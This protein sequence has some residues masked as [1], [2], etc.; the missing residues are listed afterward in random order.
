MLP[1]RLR[2]QVPLP[3]LESRVSFI[4]LKSTIIHHARRAD[5][6]LA[7]TTTTTTTIKTVSKDISTYTVPIPA[8][9]S[10]IA[11]TL[12]YVP[13][14]PPLAP[15]LHQ[16]NPEIIRKQ[17]GAFA[18]NRG[19]PS[20]VKCTKLV[21]VQNIRT[22]TIKLQTTTT[23]RPRLV[24]V[25]RT[26]TTTS[27]SVSIIANMKTTRKFFTTLTRYTWVTSTSTSIKS[28]TT[29][30]TEKVVETE[31]AA[32]GTNNLL[33]SFP[34]GRQWGPFDDDPSL[35]VIRDSGVLTDYKTPESCCGA[36]Q[37]RN[38]IC[39]GSLFYFEV[40]GHMECLHFYRQD[41]TCPSQKSALMKLSGAVGSPGAF[42]M[43]MSNGP[44][45]LF[46]EPA[47]EGSAQGK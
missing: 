39:V 36:C 37:A 1:S 35:P 26:L 16:E 4:R 18:D 47:Q 9:F 40:S 6:K 25:T 14:P 33:T 12:K 45:G 19:F 20:A 15:A 29:T 27:T 8:G 21:K 24:Y 41:N 28:T 43:F 5:S 10:N 46:Y 3:A 17:V 30:E 2:S 13:E 38:D 32:C 42:T 22:T 44:C 7:A 11:D 34:D 31:Y 23:L